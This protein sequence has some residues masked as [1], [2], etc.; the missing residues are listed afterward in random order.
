MRLI[1]IL[2]LMTLAI[3]CSS[4]YYSAMEKFGYEK[5]DILAS[6]VEDAKDDQIKAR[7]QFKTTLQRFQELTGFQGGEL[8]AKYK[9]LDSQYNACKDRADAVSSRIASVDKVAKDL[10]AEWKQELQQ[11]SNASLR[12][13]SE[14]ELAQSQTRYDQLITAMRKS[15]TKMQP[16]LTAFH[17]QVLFLKHN[18][19]AQ[20]IASLQGEVTKVDTDV[21]SL[22]RDMDQAIAEA[23]KFINAMRQNQPAK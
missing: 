13:Q 4:T 2:A 14:R 15:E 8:E 12:Q 10:F 16:V 19:N 11:Y 7:D 20:A 21:Q 5:R 6:R 17:D 18:L 9:Q 22:V 1:L 3:G 23:D